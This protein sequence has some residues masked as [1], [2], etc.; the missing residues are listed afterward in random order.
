[1]QKLK[2]KAIDD[3]F[4]AEEKVFD[5]KDPQSALEEIKRAKEAMKKYYSNQG[6]IKT[7]ANFD[8]EMLNGALL[9]IE[10]K[11]AYEDK[12]FQKSII[13]SDLAIKQL[14]HT[15]RDFK[16]LGL[17]EKQKS[18]PYQFLG[19]DSKLWLGKALKFRS[20]LEQKTSGKEILSYLKKA[21]SLFE[22]IIN[23]NEEIG[24]S[25]KTESLYHLCS[26]KMKSWNGKINKFISAYTLLDTHNK[27][28]EKT[29]PFYN[30][31]QRLYEQLIDQSVN[32]FLIENLLN[33]EKVNNTLEI[34]KIKAT[35]IK[36]N[37]NSN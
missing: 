29:D 21:E 16:E 18:L 7:G 10:A 31:I 17:I 15:Y 13:K 37:I 12:N 6:I 11:I 8:F 36:Y 25:S 1:M 2:S 24:N 28:I 23:T 9:Y 3:I 4:I 27:R 19:I 14:K 26:S 32:I 22:E 30:K 35:Q 33:T 5:E 20:K 34:G